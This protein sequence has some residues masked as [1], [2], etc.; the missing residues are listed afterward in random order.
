MTRLALSQ[1]LEQL[2]AILHAIPLLKKKGYHLPI[3]GL[4][5]SSIDSI[6]GLANFKDLVRKEIEV[7]G[8]VNDNA[9]N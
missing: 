4:D 6:S 5:N 1:L 2:Q 8:Q 9:N 7:L 3:L